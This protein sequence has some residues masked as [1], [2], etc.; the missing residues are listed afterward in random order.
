MDINR[1][2]KKAEKQKKYIGQHLW[3]SF[4]SPTM[5]WIW[6]SCLIGIC[7]LFTIIGKYNLSMWEQREEQEIYNKYWYTK[8]STRLTIINKV[9]EQ[10]SKDNSSG[11]FWVLMKNDR[12]KKITLDVTPG[13]YMDIKSGDVRYFRVNKKQFDNETGPKQP[14]GDLY[15]F[16]VGFLPLLLLVFYAFIYHALE[17]TIATLSVCYSGTV[18]DK[19]KIRQRH[20]DAGLICKDVD[21]ELEVDKK[22]LKRIE[23]ILFFASMC[24]VISG[25]I[26][27]IYT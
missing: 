22:I 6:L 21:D 13:T 27:L 18:I 3:Y 16:I 17:S 15:V 9:Q 24:S 20:R 4:T 11:H 14:C 10:P 23:L 5:S 19:D 2:N 1:R 25:I 12:G 8:E 7:C 26:F